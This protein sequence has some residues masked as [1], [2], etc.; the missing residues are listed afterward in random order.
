V[1]KGMKEG[2]KGEGKEERKGESEISLSLGP[3]YLSIR[4]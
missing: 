4:V 3:I 2:R 1:G